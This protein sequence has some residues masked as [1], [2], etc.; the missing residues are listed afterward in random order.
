[1]PHLF[2]LAPAEL[3]FDF[4]EF[5]SLSLSQWG[6]GV[7]SG[8]YVVEYDCGGSL[9]GDYT[10][11]CSGGNNCT[12]TEITSGYWMVPTSTTTYNGV[13][14]NT[15]NNYTWS[16]ATPPP[17]SSAPVLLRKSKKVAGKK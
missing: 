9:S 13:V 16:S 1:M 17:S 4:A 8:S 7:N 15:F 3:L 5:H 12:N 6:T 14:S 10:Y 11:D 2:T